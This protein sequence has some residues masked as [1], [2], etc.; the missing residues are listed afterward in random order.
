[1][2][3]VERRGVDIGCRTRRERECKGLRRRLLKGGRR[4]KLSE[5]GDLRTGWRRDVG[6]RSGSNEV[7]GREKGGEG[8]RELKLSWR[9]GRRSTLRLREGLER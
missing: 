7:L 2:L 5:R 9:G 4:L 8:K 1:M 3:E 6:G